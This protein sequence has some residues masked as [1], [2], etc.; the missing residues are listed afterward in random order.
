L[1]TNDEELVETYEGLT[2]IERTSEQKY[3][4][5]VISANGD[6]MANINS[7]KKKSIGIIRKILTKL[8]SLHLKFPLAPMGVLKI[9][10]RMCPQSHLQTS[11][12]FPQKSYPM[13]RTPTTTSSRF[14]LI[15]SP[16]LGFFGGV[17]QFF[18][19]LVS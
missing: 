17:P 18:S 10:R 16:K 19:S 2:P 12:P 14:F 4:G 9:F 7:M 13:F 3:F 6:N 5:F 1:E 8:E 11:S 15:C